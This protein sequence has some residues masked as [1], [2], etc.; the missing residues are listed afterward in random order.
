MF[1]KQTGWDG[2]LKSIL[3]VTVLDI[4]K[5]VTVLCDTLKRHHCYRE[6]F[7]RMVII[8]IS[9]ISVKYYDQRIINE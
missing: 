8:V 2:L 6:V 4:C 3:Q 1:L 5:K 9:N 7:T